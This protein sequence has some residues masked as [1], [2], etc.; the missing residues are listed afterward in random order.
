MQ[1]F[2]TTVHTLLGKNGVLFVENLKQF[3]SSDS[4]T[5]SMSLRL[6]YFNFSAGGCCRYI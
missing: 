2:V 6:S 5:S 3:T 1:I 4:Y